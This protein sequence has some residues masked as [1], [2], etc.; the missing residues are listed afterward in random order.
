MRPVTPVLAAPLER[1]SAAVH[2]KRPR[3]TLRAFLAH[4]PPRAGVRTR[5]L[6]PGIQALPWRDLLDE[7]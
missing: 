6:S 5:A 3:S 1:L 4:Q 7:L 2:R